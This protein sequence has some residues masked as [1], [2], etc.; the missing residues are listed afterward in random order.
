ML[1]NTTTYLIFLPLVFVL[2]WTM[3]SC[4]SQNLV[5]LLASMVFYGWWS[6]PCLGLMVGTC[7]LNYLFV[8]L[9]QQHRHRKPW[10]FLSL[11]LN[12]GVLGIFKYFNFF[13]ENLAILLN[14][15]GIRADMPTLNIILPVGISFYTFQLSGYVI[16]CYKQK[17]A[18]QPLLHFLTFISFFP[19]LVAGPIER[20]SHLLPQI[21]TRRTF[22][23]SEG[24]NGLRLILLGLFKKMVIAD[25]CAVPVDIIFANPSAFTTPVLLLGGVMFAAQIYGDFSGYSDIAK[26]SALLLGIHL[27]TNF[28]SPYLATS[29]A[30]FWRR[31]HITLQLWLRDYVYIPLGGSRCKPSRKYL[32]VLIVFMLSGLWHGAAWTFVLWGVYHA[33]LIIFSRPQ[34]HLQALSLHFHRLFVFVLVCIGW[35]IFRCPTLTALQTYFTSLTHWKGTLLPPS[36]TIAC[37]G[38]TAALLLWFLEYR[39]EQRSISLDAL[40]KPFRWSLYVLTT[41]IIIVFGGDNSAFIYF[42]F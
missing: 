12:F 6:V 3:R 14:T 40:S 25:N 29:I 1:F 32:N 10:L 38:M 41:L 30:D 28:K 23:Y 31:W 5:L 4:R 15:V 20:G 35:V 27:S 33:I 42:Q 13:A 21:Q 8:L 37:V 7:L 39:N 26:G 24:V 11:L 34:T 16:D 18:S 9:M 2:Y 22:S 19:Q 17:P 36:A